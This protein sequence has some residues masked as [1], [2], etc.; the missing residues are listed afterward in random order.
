MSHEDVVDARVGGGAFEGDEV[1]GL[2]DDEDGGAVTARVGADGAGV[3]LGEVVAD[4][5]V[6]DGAFDIDN[7]TE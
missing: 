3:G 4:R 5:T 2:L 7:M 6:A 1:F